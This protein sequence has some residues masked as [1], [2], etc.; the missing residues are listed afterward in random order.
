MGHARHSLSR[1]VGLARRKCHA[2]PAGHASLGLYRSCWAW[3]VGCK[4]QAQPGPLIWVVPC[5]AH[6]CSK[7][8]VLVM[9]SRAMSWVACSDAHA[10]P[11]SLSLK[12][13]I[14]TT[15]PPMAS[16]LVSSLL[17]ISAT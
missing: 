6:F 5:M 17:R 3:A 16:F 1:G 10:Y 11:S 12:V 8:A 15:S 14:L 7:W 13:L 4:P 2:W 9:P